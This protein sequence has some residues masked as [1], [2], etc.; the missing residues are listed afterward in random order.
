VSLSR[1]E[2]I[3]CPAC[4]H[5]QSFVVWSSVNVSIDP[6]LKE[7]FLDGHLITFHCAQ[8]SKSAHVAY[9]VLYHD[10]DHSFAVWLKHPEDD[11]SFGIDNLAEDV[12]SLFTDRYICRLVPSFQELVEKVRIFDD[13]FDDYAIELLKLLICIRERI[14]ITC[15]FYYHITER[16][17]LSGRSIVFVLPTKDDLIEKRYPLRRHMESV[18]PILAKLKISN[19]QTIELWPYVDREYMLRWLESAGLMRQIE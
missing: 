19:L 11:G 15:P 4:G 3:A 17:L 10:M 7:S 14:D 8:C 12:S 9:D 18:E 1:Q 13:G 2:R 16:R 5:Q 6:S